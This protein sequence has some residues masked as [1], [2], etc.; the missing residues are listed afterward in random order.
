MEKGQLKWCTASTETSKHFK[1][2][3]D[4]GL[5]FI[6]LLKNNEKYASTL[7]QKQIVI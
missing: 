6:T 4:R 2:Y 5:N 1:D 7:F 3:K